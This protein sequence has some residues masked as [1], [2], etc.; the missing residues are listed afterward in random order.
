VDVVIDAG[1]GGPIDT[2]AVGPNG[3]AEKEINLRVALATHD[4]LGERGIASLLTR[5]GDYPIPIPT[6]SAYADEVGARALVSLHHNSPQAPSSEV[7]GVEVF[8]QHDSEESMRLGGLLYEASVDALQ[9]FEVDWDRAA[10]A[11]VMTVL[12]PDGLDA[13]GMVRLPETPSA[14]IELGYLANPVEADLYLTAEYVRTAA[15]AVADAIE[16]FLTTADDG[17]ALVE[18]RVFRPRSGVGKDQ[19]VDVDLERDLYPDVVAT[20][21]TGDGVYSFEVTMSS[22]YD[23]PERY[24][25]AFRVIGDDGVTYGVRE[26]LH[27]HASEQPFTR[28]LD[29]ITI[30]DTVR[31]V[32]IEGRDLEYGWGGQTFRVELP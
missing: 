9:A 14:L 3:L 31:A 12:N 11:G 4:M 1:H 19:C 18:G 21:I 15:T 10:D 30:P 17:A 6:R 7:P 25:D 32:T 13:Y 16:A 27:D 5:M 26:L 2:G 22:P 28:S 8:V 24:A 29:G 23:T 20:T